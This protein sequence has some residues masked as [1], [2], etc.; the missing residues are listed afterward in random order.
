MPAES[1]ELVTGEETNNELQE[2]QQEFATVHDAIDAIWCNPPSQL[3]LRVPHKPVVDEADVKR[4]EEL[5]KK[6]ESLAVHL[7]EQT[8]AEVDAHLDPLTLERFV[9]ARPTVDGAASMFMAT[10]A[11]RVERNLSHLYAELH[12]TGWGS[13]SSSNKAELASAHFYGGLVGKTRKGYPL[14][15]E[16]LGRL[17]LDG[18]ARSPAAREAVVDAYTCYLEGIFRVVRASAAAEGRLVRAVLV[19]DLAGAAWSMLRHVSLLQGNS[20]IAVENYPELYAPILIVNAPGWI[21][22]AWS[23]FSA[24][25]R[26]RTCA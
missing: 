2:Q 20:K 10:M 23:L 19:V 13:G 16:R 9:L 14:F 25:C 8:Q 26:I 21:A 3:R 7:D 11:W 1:V 5:R 18:M 17:D 15:V 6:V 12:P 4:V 22:G 24:C